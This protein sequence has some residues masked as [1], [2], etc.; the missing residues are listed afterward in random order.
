MR[1]ESFDTIKCP[2]WGDINDDDGNEIL[3]KGKEELN[4]G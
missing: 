1:R 2:E 3:E 4:G